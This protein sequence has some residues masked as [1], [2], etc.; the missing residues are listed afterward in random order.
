MLGA[1]SAES[2][3]AELHAWIAEHDSPERA[4]QW[5]DRVLDVI[6]TLENS[7]ER[8]AVPLELRDL[9]MQEYRQVYFKPY[10]VVYRVHGRK[11]VVY[12]IVDGRRDL[13]SALTRRLL[14]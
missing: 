8:G 12:L 5:L 3:L 10:R 6:A 13:S 14:D 2:D 4:D 9:A 11:V 1:A 7:P